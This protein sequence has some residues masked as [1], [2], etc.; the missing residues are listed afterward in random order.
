MQTHPWS[1]AKTNIAIVRSPAKAVGGATIRVSRTPALPRVAGLADQR[2]TT[3]S[4]SAL[5]HPA[6]NLGSEAAQQAT[7][8]GKRAVRA[9]ISQLREVSQ[10]PPKGRIPAYSPPLPDAGALP[11]RERHVRGPGHGHLAGAGL[12][13]RGRQLDSKLASPGRRLPHLR[14]VM[15]DTS[16]RTNALL[17]ET[18]GSAGSGLSMQGSRVAMRS[19]GEAQ[20][21]ASTE[22]SIHSVASSRGAQ[23]ASQIALNSLLHRHG[24]P[25]ACSG[26][27][28]HRPV[29][30]A[31]HTPDI[32]FKRC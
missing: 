29:S 25:T 8:A 6:Q 26:V 19:I 17:L 32:K 9:A 14:A 28:L 21:A 5:G 15:M 16:V 2:T 27:L 22:R 24:T 20:R 31:P 7:P 18:G 12:T 4:G 30:G 1:P 10:V 23:G 13:R 3:D 11:R